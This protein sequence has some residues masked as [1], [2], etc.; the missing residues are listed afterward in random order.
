MGV[1]VRNGRGTNQLLLHCLEAVCPLHHMVALDATDVQTG[2]S[3]HVAS[4]C[5]TGMLHVY[6]Q[7]CLAAIWH[8]WDAAGVQ[9]GVTC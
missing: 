8:H 4:A 5:V 2:L 6:K 3:I 9:T 1:V 7:A